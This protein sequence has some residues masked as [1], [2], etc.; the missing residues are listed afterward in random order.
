MTNWYDE[1]IEEPLR[2]IVRILRNNGINTECSCGHEKYIQCQYLLDGDVRTINSLLFNYFHKLGMNEPDFT[3]SVR[4]QVIKGHQYSSLEVK[5]PIEQTHLKHLE[6][7]R[8]HL[9]EQLAYHE[10]FVE[11]FKD[12]IKQISSDISLEK[13]ET[14]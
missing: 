10:K 8:S 6:E 12:R 13:Q 3:I 11:Y 7:K 14:I 9:E 4:H 5:F 1:K 2:D